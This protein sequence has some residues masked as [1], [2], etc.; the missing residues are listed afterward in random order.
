MQLKIGLVNPNELLKKKMSHDIVDD[1]SDRLRNKHRS[2]ILCM[3]NGFKYTS[4][5]HRIGKKLHA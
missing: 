4:Y 5:T 3:Q 1:E 2:V